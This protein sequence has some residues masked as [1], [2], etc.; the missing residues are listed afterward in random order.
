MR[1]GGTVT[2]DRRS[3]FVSPSLAEKGAPGTNPGSGN[4]NVRTHH[5]VNAVLTE[6][7]CSRNWT[8]FASRVCSLNRLQDCRVAESHIHSCVLRPL[9]LE[10]RAPHPLVSMQSQGINEVSAALLASQGADNLA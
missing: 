5:K 3:V 9:R 7:A 8:A 10:S 4:N 1:S 2:K 6:C